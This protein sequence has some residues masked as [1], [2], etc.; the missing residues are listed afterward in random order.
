MLTNGPKPIIIAIKAIM[1]H[2]FGDQV[3]ENQTV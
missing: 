2:I 3:M 1:L